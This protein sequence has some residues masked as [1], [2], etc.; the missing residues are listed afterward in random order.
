MSEGVMTKSKVC[1]FHRGL[2]T[3]HVELSWN[4]KSDWEIKGREIWNGNR[5]WVKAAWIR[6]PVSPPI[7]KKQLLVRLCRRS[8]SQMGCNA[9]D[10]FIGSGERFN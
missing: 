6:K 7:E 3:L 5:R 4:R 9:A 1:D 10:Q 2:E 8:C